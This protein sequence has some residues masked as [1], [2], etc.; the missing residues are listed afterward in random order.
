MSPFFDCRVTHPARPAGSARSWQDIQSVREGYCQHLVLILGARAKGSISAERDKVFVL[1]HSKELISRPTFFSAARADFSVY[2]F[3]AS[4]P[5]VPKI[6]LARFPLTV[7]P[8]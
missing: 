6:F 1:T 3:A 8:L 4:L 2:E 7:K 5:E